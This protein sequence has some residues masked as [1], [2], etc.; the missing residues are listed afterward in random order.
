MELIVM[1]IVYKIYIVTSVYVSYDDIITDLEGF[2]VSVGEIE[3]N[4]E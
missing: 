1:V 2:Y 4:V 3:L